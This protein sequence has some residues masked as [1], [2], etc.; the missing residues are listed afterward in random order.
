MTHYSKTKESQISSH[1]F[2]VCELLGED[3]GVVAHAHHVVSLTRGLFAFQ[4][5]GP[6]R[7]HGVER[8]DGLLV[9]AEGRQPFDQPLRHL[10][11]GSP[12][13]LEDTD[14]TRIIR[15]DTQKLNSFTRL[16]QESRR[17]EKCKDFCELRK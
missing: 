16:T 8:G 4:G 7:R 6:L 3:E 1:Q 13:V 17:H 12:R 2:N 5:G 14:V 10:L 15:Q 11:H 9:L